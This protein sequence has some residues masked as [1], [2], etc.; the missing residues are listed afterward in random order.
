MGLL[1]IPFRLVLSMLNLLFL[2][3]GVILITGVVA[4][5]VK[6]EVVMTQIKNQGRQAEE[7]F[8]R[9]AMEDLLKQIK[10]ILGLVRML[11]LFL[12]LIVTSYAIF[13]LVGNCCNK[14]LFLKVYLLLT[15]AAL[16]VHVILLIVYFANKTTA[17][18]FITDQVKTMVENYK[19]IEEEELHAKVLPMLSS[20]LQC[21]GYESGQDFRKSKK[22]LQHEG[23]PGKIKLHGR[24]IDSEGLQYPIMCCKQEKYDQCSHKSS[25]GFT[26]ENSYITKGCKKAIED[27]IIPYTD[28]AAQYSLL[29]LL[30]CVSIIIFTALVLLL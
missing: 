16:L 18:R 17:T 19:T 4:L 7:M 20:V 21:C 28:K 5:M 24:E 11:L 6:E 2:L 23:K 25:G 27:K 13:G 29:V 14:K 26:K 3:I 1:A 8:G 9:Q 12:G 22:F 30:V 15:A 10:E